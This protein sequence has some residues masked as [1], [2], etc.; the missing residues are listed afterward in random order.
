MTTAELAALAA[1]AVAATVLAGCGVVP[2][3]V[4]SVDEPADFS[5]AL[6]IPPLAESRVENGVRVFEL[7]AQ[8][9]TTSFLPGTRSETW[10]FNGDHLGPT[11]RAG[12][13]EKVAVEITNELEEGTSV[14]WHGMHLPP[15]MDGGPHQEIEPGATWRPRWEIDQPGA[16]LWY[17]PHPHGRTEEHV[18]RG[19][20]GMFIL[21]DADTASAG[22]PQT[23]GVD[24]IPVIVQD[25]ALTADGDLDLDPDGNEVGLL[26][27]TVMTNGT[28]GAYQQVTTELVRLRLLNGS[29]ARTYALGFDDREVQ[30]VATDGG[31]LRAPV[32]TDRVR[33]SP[34][35]R[36][37]IVVVLEPG[38]TARLRSFD[39]ELGQVAAPFAV[40]A[41]DSFDVLELRAADELA[42]SE[43]V[44]AE[45]SDFGR[46]EA[47]A[48]VTRTF[49][50]DGRKINGASM[51][52]NRIDE[53]VTVGNTEIWEV[54]NLN[55]SPH[56]FHVHDVQFEVLDI[57]G[58][59]PPPDLAGRK[60]TVYLEPR[61]KYRLIM[62]FED[63]AD[64]TWPYMYHCHLL[65][66]EDEGLMGQFVVVEPGDG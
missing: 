19:L 20:A 1:S 11:L 32:T 29:T 6:A 38:T 60:D 45:L 47:D 37:E 61:R 14:H 52:M 10:G 15:E 17:H 66:H 43:P 50:L 4:S 25:K 63:Y 34:G 18:Y 59:A 65:L 26:G 2:G 51:D 3:S 9:G 58:Q 57:D 21:D 8:E 31:L 40:G 41:N 46:A 53:T 5:T 35:E 28:V 23:Y 16:T 44:A 64:P 36:A 30:L 33:L 39:P 7:T 55:L 27:T 24:D 62:R 48:T 56:N 12:R 13:G 54:R 49:E 42:P 22:L